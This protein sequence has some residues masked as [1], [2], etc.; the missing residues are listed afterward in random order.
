MENNQQKIKEL[1]QKIFGNKIT[2]LNEDGQVEKM[3]TIS[4][5][6]KC[7]KCLS[8][9]NKQ[10]LPYFKHLSNIDTMVI[11]ESPGSGKENGSL[12]FVF[13]W[14]LFEKQHSNVAIKKY[15]NYFFKVLGLDKEN[16][17]I[18]DAI[19]CYTHKNNFSVAFEECKTYLEEE[20]NILKPKKVLLISKQNKLMDFIKT[21]EKENSLKENSFQLNIIPHPSNQNISKIATVAEIFSSIGKFNSNKK[22]EK[23]GE[24]IQQEYKDLKSILNK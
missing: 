7:A 21:L 13:G 11:A 20:I 15:E 23:L 16:T 5:E 9:C 3:V 4:N 14:E 6:N 19:K 24:E 10:D 12:G 18:T 22:W 2:E 8:K 17:Y 1:Y